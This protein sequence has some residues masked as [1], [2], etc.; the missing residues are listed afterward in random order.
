[1]EGFS[2]SGPPTPRIWYLT[3][4]IHSVHI[5]P[6]M[7]AVI[8][9]HTYLERLL[10]KYGTWTGKMW[11]RSHTKTRIT[12]PLAITSFLL[13]LHPKSFAIYTLHLTLLGKL[14]KEG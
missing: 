10:C 7:M 9:P 8:F 11:G 12:Y 4:I 6:A 14:N 3:W 5:V 2:T 13:H 1:M